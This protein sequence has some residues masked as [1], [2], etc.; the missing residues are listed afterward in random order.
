MGF[1]ALSLQ[2]TSLSAHVRGLETLS[3]IVN[4]HSSYLYQLSHSLYQLKLVGDP[5][6]PQY[7]DSFDVVGRTGSNLQSAG[8][9]NLRQQSIKQS[10]EL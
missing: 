5:N 1:V 8:H 2:A 4:R 3:N 10:A 7:S 6:L 9:S